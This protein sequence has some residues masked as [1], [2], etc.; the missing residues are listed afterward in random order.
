MYAA[1]KYGAISTGC[2]LSKQQLQLAGQRVIQSGLADRVSLFEQDYRDL[3]GTFNKIAS[4][5]MVNTSV[6]IAFLN[7]SRKFTN[8]S[9]MTASCS[10]TGSQG[11]NRW[12]KVRRVCSSGAMFFQ[13]G[14]LPKLSDVL[15]A[16]EN[17]GFEVLDVEN[18]RRHYARTCKAWV[19]NLRTNTVQCLRHVDMPTLRTWIIFLTGSAVKFED[20]DLGLHQTLLCKR[21][22]RRYHPTTRAYMYAPAPRPKARAA[23]QS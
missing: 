16:A 11:P 2:T 6:S 7:I 21:G 15:R 17:A 18:L 20:G 8:C 1:Q 13:A 19:E 14:E 23:H 22:R 4:V 3:P 5:G 10:I 12:T 9:A